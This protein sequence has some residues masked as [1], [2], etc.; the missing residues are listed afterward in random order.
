VAAGI[1]ETGD[2][3]RPLDHAEIGHDHLEPRNGAV[4][5]DL[6]RARVG[7][8]SR[9]TPEPEIDAVRT[10]APASSSRQPPWLS[11][12]VTSTVSALKLSRVARSPATVTNCPLPSCPS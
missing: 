4:E 1:F 12:L 7:A 2:L 8:A 5:E 11:R 6:P 3:E 10:P 9:K